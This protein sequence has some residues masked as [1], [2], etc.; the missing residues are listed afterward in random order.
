MLNI[1]NIDSWDR[2]EHYQL[3]INQNQDLCDDFLEEKIDYEFI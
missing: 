1:I 2:K 3:F